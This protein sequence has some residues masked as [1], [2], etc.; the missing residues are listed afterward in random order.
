MGPGESCAD[1]LGNH[2]ITVLKAQGLPNVVGLVQGL[3]G[4]PPRH[5]ADA[6]KECT[7]FFHSAFDTQPKV[8]TLDSEADCQQLLRHLHN[9][10]PKCVITCQLSNDLRRPISYRAQRCYMLAESV[11]FRPDPLRPDVV[12]ARWSLARCE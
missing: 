10:T 8:L 12:S 7:R 5:R 6:K 2:F 1:D 9:Q 3:A 11:E 4:V